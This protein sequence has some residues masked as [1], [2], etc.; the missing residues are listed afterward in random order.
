MDRDTIR[1]AYI[2]YCI[3]KNGYFGRDDLMEFFG[4]STATASKVI[5]E[6]GTNDLFFDGFNSFCYVAKDTWKPRIC[7]ISDRDREFFQ[8]M[9]KK[10]ISG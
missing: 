4:I 5:R 10:E 8:W 6:Y 1:L 7:E 9:G 2:D 3:S